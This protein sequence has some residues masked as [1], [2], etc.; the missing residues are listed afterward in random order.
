[1]NGTP[2]IAFSIPDPTLRLVSAP[3]PLPSVNAVR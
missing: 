3:I 2:N 1:M